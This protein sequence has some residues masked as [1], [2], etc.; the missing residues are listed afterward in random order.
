MNV[1]FE[2]DPCCW[3][4]SITLEN[5]YFGAIM[6]SDILIIVTSTVTWR[7]KFSCFADIKRFSLCNNFQRRD[8]CVFQLQVMCICLLKKPSCKKE[9]V[10]NEGKLRAR[11]YHQKGKSLRPLVL[12]PIS[13]DLNQW[14][15][16]VLNTWLTEQQSSCQQRPPFCSVLLALSYEQ[17]KT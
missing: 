13:R 1:D 14:S 9:S 17:V 12:T 16:S 11:G 6:F 2:D 10:V 4:C 3:I 8:V 7:G 15:K 5:H